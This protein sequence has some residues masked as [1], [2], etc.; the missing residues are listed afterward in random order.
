MKTIKGNLIDLF[1]EGEFDVM[2]HGCNCFRAMASGIAGQITKKIPEA[3]FADNLYGTEG[4]NAKLSHYSAAPVR[5]EGHSVG[6]V[7]NL[8]TQYKPWC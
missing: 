3:V 4:D 5:R 1:L 7:I 8:Y 6:I 2:I